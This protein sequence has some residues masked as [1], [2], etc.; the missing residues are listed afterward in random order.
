MRLSSTVTP[1]LAVASLFLLP[2]CTGVHTGSTMPD[3]DD[4]G[5]STERVELELIPNAKLVKE[6]TSPRWP[7]GR[8]AFDR[9]VDKLLVVS[10]ITALRPSELG[11]TKKQAKRDFK[12]ERVWI[13][14]PY[15]T[16]MGQQLKLEDLEE[17]FLAGYD[18]GL[19][20]DASFLQPNRLQ[21]FVTLLEQN[22][23]TATAHLNVLIQPQRSPTWSVNGLFEQVPVKA[24][25]IRAHRVDES[26]KMAVRPRRAGES[27]LTRREPEMVDASD[28]DEAKADDNQR[29]D[30]ADIEIPGVE[31]RQVEAAAAFEDVPLAGK[32]RGESPSFEIRLQIIPAPEPRFAMASYRR[33]NPQPLLRE[34]RYRIQK[35]YLILQVE[36]LENAPRAG[37]EPTHLVLRMNL[38]PEEL[39]L[40]GNFGAREGA[41]RMSLQRADFADMLAADDL[42]AD[43][44]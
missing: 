10:R 40:D 25:G 36:R 9:G 29:A 23:G 42:R 43:A 37:S 5:E 32:W 12:I 15:G 8:Y 33:G 30:Q 44:E 34:G 4:T 20:G 35:D 38:E 1:L 14:I 2:A 41:M 11:T 21:G 3:P 18:E 6:D 13:T 16:E 39:T 24:E 22:D 27:S 7:H 28:G 26:R 19:I 31:D 17:E